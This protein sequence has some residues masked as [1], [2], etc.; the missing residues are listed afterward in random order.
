MA[1]A[2]IGIFGAKPAER[3]E[4][5]KAIAKKD[6]DADV[7][8][9]STIA[10]GCVYSVVEPTLYPEKPMPAVF[11][12]NLSDYCVFVAREPSREFAETLVLLDLLG[13][14]KGALLTHG[15][16]DDFLKDTVVEGYDRLDS[17]DA[18]KQ[19]VLAF[20]GDSKLDAL[21]LKCIVDNSFEV[22]GV[23]CVALG[24]IRQGVLKQYDSLFAEPGGYEVGVKSIQVH[25]KD[26][27]MAYS[28]DRFGIGFKGASVEQVKRGTVLSHSREETN[29]NSFTVTLSKF[30]DAIEPNTVLHAIVG[31]QFVGCHVSEALKPGESKKAEIV[32]EKPVFLAG[33]PVLLLN[34]NAKKSRIVGV[35][36]V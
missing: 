27:K 21:P 6:S 4:V 3:E 7:S 12:A 14:T 22:K 18:V 23:G 5:A 9:Y 25:D 19:A 34:L 10:D 29:E 11:A 26:V 33:E 24:V 13:K 32:F 28:G 1:S 16:L 8:Y 31:L 35:G 20:R 2:N 15:G 17:V 30:A 36:R